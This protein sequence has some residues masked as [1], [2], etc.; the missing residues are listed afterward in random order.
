[1]TTLGM[2]YER[3]T[4]PKAQLSPSIKEIAWAAGIF[5]GEGH[6][7][8]VGNGRQHSNSTTQKATVVQKDPWI[9][10][11]ISVYFGGKISKT[12]KGHK[13]SPLACYHWNVY[14]SRA[15]GFLMTIYSFL[16]PRR[17][18]QIRKL[19]FLNA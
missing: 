3:A 19:G 5:E 6:C 13:S 1:M 15:R 9:L 17:K 8:N 12:N 11:Q 14:G 16:S 4:T 2:S 10:Y 7:R 18:E